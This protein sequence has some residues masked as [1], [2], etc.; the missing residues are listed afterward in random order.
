MKACTS[1]ASSPG[2]R[3]AWFE[4]LLIRHY[5]S[6]ESWNSWWHHSSSRLDYCNA[7]LA[8]LPAST[9]ICHFNVHRMPPPGQA[10]VHRIT[11]K[12]ATLIHQALHNRRCPPYLADLV[13]FSSTDSSAA[14]FHH[15]QSSR[16]SRERT[17]TQFGR[18]GRLL[19][20]RSRSVEQSSSV[21]P[22]R[23]L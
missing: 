6:K 16:E 7:I 11:F 14:P 15:D 12:V 4:Y 18:L 3:N 19:C 20:L 21:C 2:R 5:V 9:L 8:G 22:H 1:C 10:R 17:R 13:A 23:R